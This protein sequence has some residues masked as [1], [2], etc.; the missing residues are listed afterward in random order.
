MTSF[1]LRLLALALMLVDHAGM[2]LLP[3]V[4]ILRGIGRAAFPLYCFLLTQGFIHTRSRTRYTLRLCVF[5][6]VSEIPYDLFLFARPFSV[7]EQNVLFTLALSLVTLCA[8]ERYASKEP[9]TAMVCT[10]ALC[11][12]AMLT[13]VSYAWLGIMLCLCFYAFSQSPVKLSAGMLA[14][15]GMYMVSLALS[16]TALWFVL[17]HLFAAAALVPILLYN[18]ER[19]PRRLQWAFYLSYPVSL[20]LLTAARNARLI[21]PYLFF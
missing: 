14:L 3:T 5:A 19:G 16:G 13:R 7:L 15:Y 20:L 9:L 18:G 21:P 2:A 17:S 4:P 11:L 1:T 12:T 8:V 6:L 10:L